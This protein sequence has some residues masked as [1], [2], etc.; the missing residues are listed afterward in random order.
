MLK[1]HPAADV[2]PLL[3][4]AEFDALVDSIKA[5]G[6]LNPIVLH[7]DGSIIDGRNRYRACLKAGVE[8]R[9]VTWD[10]KGS[11][12]EYVVALNVDRRHLDA[13]ARALLGKQL[14]PLY[15]AE[16]KARQREHGKTA[17]GRKSVE[18]KVSQVRAPQARELAAKAA[19][20]NP[21][22]ISDLNRI[23]KQAPAIFARI[24]A[25]EIELPEAKC[26]LRRM[27]AEQRLKAAAKLA[28]PDGVDLR[29][30]A[31]EKL[32]A[33]VRGI[34]LILSDPPYGA[35]HVQLYGTLAR[36][37]SK[38]LKPEGILARHVRA[39][40]PAADRGGRAQAHLV[41]VGYG[42][43]DDGRAVRAGVEPE[44]QHVLEAGRDLRP[45][46]PRWQ[47][48][49]RLGAQRDG[50]QVARRVAAER[51]RFIR[52]VEHLTLPHALVCD[53]FCEVGTTAVACV[54]L[55]RRIVGCD[56]DADAV[57]TARARCALEV[58]PN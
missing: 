1:F 23:E 15:A 12:T 3:Q 16:A 31:M 9:F 35:E 36:L 25:H 56:I 18:Q 46:A 53:P 44:G 54:R 43:H 22:Y 42:V 5:K 14:E 51:V 39:V 17:P 55:H 40:L 32:L 52:L 38:A 30:C 4:G 10:G 24:E 8:P 6:L 37:A 29:E 2:F 19:R 13:R 34:D 49:R 20:T 41:P 11:L 50:R 48:A 27:Q 58:R 47:V 33:E 45:E 7:P 28:R 26:L 21:Q 57:K